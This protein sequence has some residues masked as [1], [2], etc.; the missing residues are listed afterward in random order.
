MKLPWYY[1]TRALGVVMVLF[2]LFADS[3]GDRSTILLIGGGLLG[4]DKVATKPDA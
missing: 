2:G 1:T 3:T 4:L